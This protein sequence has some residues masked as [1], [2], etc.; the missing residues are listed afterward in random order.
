VE[1]FIS[2]LWFAVTIWLITRAAG[3]RGLLPHLA[4]ATPPPPAQALQVVVIVPARDEEANLG[5][6]LQAPAAV[7]LAW[8]AVAVP[9]IDA[10]LWVQSW[11]QL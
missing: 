4:P 1:L 9:V 3:Q 8:A 11:G 7:V 2:S 5:T 10:A 6:C